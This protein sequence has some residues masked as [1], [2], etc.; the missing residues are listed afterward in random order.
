M[1]EME[2]GYRDDSSLLSTPS[3]DFREKDTGEYTYAEVCGFAYGLEYML[4][5]VAETGFVGDYCVRFRDDFRFL[6]HPGARCLQGVERVPS[7]ASQ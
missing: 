4:I 6:P 7:I 1:Y 5:L 3:E 2:E